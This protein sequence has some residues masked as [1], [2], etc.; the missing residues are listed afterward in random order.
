MAIRQKQLRKKELRE[1]PLMTMISEAQL[2]LA[3]NG[4]KLAIGVLAAAV[5]IVAVVLL[6]NMRE[7]ADLESREA[8]ADA[9][10][11]IAQTNPED[12]IPPLLRVAD[13]YQGTSGGSEALYTAAEM[14]LNEQNSELAIE[15]F[16]R[17][18]KEYKG[19]YLLE[20]G[21]SG[22]LATAL[23]NSG[24]FEEAAD[25][26]MKLADD[27]DA[28]DYRYFALLNAGKAYAHAEQYDKARAAFNIVVNEQEQSNTRARAQEELARLDVIADGIGLP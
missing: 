11:E 6:Q 14:A 16:S 2:W 21:A 15:L 3:V 5:V 4:K 13:D 26:Y 17:F 28:R 22:G 1:D 10:L 20:A 7:A 18:L 12:V 27:K 23:E 24:K 9:Q 25:L 19:E 8:F